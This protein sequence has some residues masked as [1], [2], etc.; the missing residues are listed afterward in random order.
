[1]TTP[2]PEFIA[3]YPDL[4]TEEEISRL[5]HAFYGRARKDPLLGPIFEAHVTNWDAHFV[6]MIDFWSMKL[7]GTS[8]FRGAPMPKHVALPGLTA[9]LFERWLQLFRETTSEMENR[10]LQF[11]ADM[12]AL[13][14]GGRLWL[15][16]QIER[17]PD[18]QLV[19]LQG[20]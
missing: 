10:D 9:E 17:Y 13:H 5:V 3:P 18:R 1:M 2:Q 12:L 7:R 14:I 15:R 4:C 11:N 6:Q 16:Y 19:E 8:H 20:A